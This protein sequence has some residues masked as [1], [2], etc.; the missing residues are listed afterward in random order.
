MADPKAHPLSTPSGLIELTGSFHTG[1]GLSAAPEQRKPED[2]GEYPFQ[3][4]TPKVHNRI[5]SQGCNLAWTQ[6]SDQQRLWLNPA[7]GSELGLSDGDPALVE[8]SIGRVRVP[9]RLTGDIRPGAACLAEGAWPRFDGQGVEIAGSANA[10]TST[11]PTRPSMG[12][13]TH[14]VTVRIVKAF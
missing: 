5:H 1:A 14:S 3:L 11:E 9:V 2:L 4:V 13:R 8:N 7:D 12:S 10:L 6:S